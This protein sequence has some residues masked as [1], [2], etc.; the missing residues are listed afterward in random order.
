MFAKSRTLAVFVLTCCTTTLGL[1]A[2]ASIAQ[3]GVRPPSPGT[4]VLQPGDG[5]ASEGAGTTG[6]S[7]ADAAHVV[8]VHN[9]AE[10]VSALGNGDSTPKIIQVRGMIDFNTAADGTRLTCDDY[11]TGGYT[12][13]AY[14]AAYDPAT[15][16]SASP[17][18]PQEAARVA[19][20]KRQA[21]RVKVRVGSNT[22]I[23][24]L[25]KGA[26]LR[27]GSL[28]VQNAD[29]VIV[30]NIDFSNASDCFPAWAPNSG[31]KSEYDNLEITS[32]RH[33]WIDHNTF[34]DGDEP[35]TSL[36]HYFGYIFEK[37]DGL[38]DIVRGSD[39]VTVSW[40]VFKDHDKT[41][42]VGNSDGA[43]ATDSSR[44]RV[45]LH[46]NLYKD[47][48]QRAPRVRFGKVDAY[49][50]HYVVSPTSSGAYVYSLGVGYQSQL[51][52]EANAFTV[53]RSIG[54]GKV[55]K[56]WSGTSLTV[57]QNYVNGVETDLLTLHNESFP[58]EHLDDGAGW[59]PT[60]RLRVDSPSAVP[61]IVCRHAGA[62]RI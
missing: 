56:S 52:A 32:S 51:V 20:Q 28:T 7:A 1:T 21:A 42:L 29:N 12:R 27:G 22:T 5:W 19:S 33:V 55:I 3:A 43:A 35:D 36:P 26:T 46:H 40:N 39:L 37:H 44:L 45:T 57:R 24:G 59:A 61:R 9:R 47:V 2:P 48:G 16:G 13:A 4:A 49:N 58:S 8:T 18:G 23:V 14:L 41:T 11:A 17:A 25:G 10:L 53:P 50:N 6:G 34:S 62:G 30:R 15:W 31:W 60:L 38:L 54:L